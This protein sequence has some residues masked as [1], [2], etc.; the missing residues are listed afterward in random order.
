MSKDSGVWIKYEVLLKCLDPVLEA[1]YIKDG[2]RQ[3]FL[4]LLNIEIMKC[5]MEVEDERA[6][7]G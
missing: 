4:E 6:N 5:K 3:Q 2:A 7:R 1:F